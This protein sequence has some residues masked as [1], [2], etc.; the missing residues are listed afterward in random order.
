[1]LLIIRPLSVSLTLQ[2]IQFLLITVTVGLVLLTGLIYFVGRKTGTSPL[3]N[4]AALL[5]FIIGE[6][7]SKS[8]REQFET[9]PW[10]WIKGKFAESDVDVE[11]VTHKHTESK[12][13]PVL[14]E[15]TSTIVLGQ[16]GKGKSSFVKSRIEEWDYDGATIAH[17]ISE[18]NGYNEYVDFF[19]SQGR[20]V[21]VISSRDSDVRWNPF[22]DYGET[23][24]D[25]ETIAESI[26]ETEDIIETGWTEPAKTL[27]VA[28]LI[29][30]SA[31]HG[32][33]VKLPQIL[34][35]GPEWIVEEVG[36]VDEADLIHRPLA[37]NDRD[38]LNTAYTTLLNSL[39]PLLQSELFNEELPPISL[40]E[41]FKQPANRVLVLNNVLSDTFATGFWRFLLQVAIEITL[42]ES[43][44][45]Q[46]LLD[47]F[48]KL[49]K[50]E[51]LTQLV[52]AGRSP[53]ATAILVSQ[54]VPLVKAIYGDETHSLYNQSPN[55][56]IFNPGGKETAELALDSIGSYEV[57]EKQIKQKVGSDSKQSTTRKIEEKRPLTTQQLL[58]M[59]TG[60]AV[61]HSNNN[62]WK[63][64]IAEYDS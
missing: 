13:K 59:E 4:V 52:S 44:Q 47:E 35:Q 6:E 17:S 56:V 46:F 32:D 36:K 18:P 63:C 23:V 26:F 20:V 29:I 62:W 60:W 27:L 19:E 25:M 21:A 61:I 57:T 9:G 41:Y 38:A 1:M 64:K 42:D 58:D 3:Q 48:D 55:R 10:T 16:T 22:A 12:P 37:T 11:R 45:Q 5:R 39:R 30:T 7:V 24:N 34:K 2:R 31:R 51:S 49:P 50:I 28:A 15:N 8:G 40:R 53:G 33:I 54:D 14:D 43:N